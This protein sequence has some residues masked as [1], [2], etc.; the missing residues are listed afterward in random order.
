MPLRIPLIVNNALLIYIETNDVHKHIA[1][2][3][4]Y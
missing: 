2:I 4:L 3:D 1:A